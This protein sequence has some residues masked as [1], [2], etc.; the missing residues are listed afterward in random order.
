MPIQFQCQQCGHAMQLPDAS[1]GKQGK[2][3]KCGVAVTVPAPG[4]AL[5]A[6][7]EEFWSELPENEPKPAYYEEEKEAPKSEKKTDAQVLKTYFKDDTEEKILQRT[8]LPWEDSDEGFFDRYWDTAIAIMNHPLDAWATMKLQDGFGKPVTFLLMGAVFGSFFSM[9]Y[10]VLFNLVMVFSNSQAAMEAAAKA[11]EKASDASG[12]P[13]TAEAVAGITTAVILTLLLIL[14]LGFVINVIVM[15]IGGFVQAGLMQ[16]MLMVVGIK[17]TNYQTTFRVVAY[18]QG[19]IMV[20]TV[21]PVLGGL[22]ATGL[23][24]AGMITGFANAYDTTQGK[25]AAAV[26]LY[27]VPFMLPVLIGV[28]LLARMFI[29][30]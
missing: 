1:A 23:W 22:L 6:Q 11:A 4:A 2:C 14:C 7:D 26:L 9:L 24:F 17:N 18:T 3:P 27:F 16:L 21:V 30:I 25:A 28:V 8:G 29:G 5:S 19:S 15:L 13:E 20:W 10:A 12:S